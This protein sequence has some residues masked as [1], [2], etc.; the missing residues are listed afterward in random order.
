MTDPQVQNRPTPPEGARPTSETGA[1]NLDLLGS[2]L[3]AERERLEISLREL[4]RRIEVSPSLISQIERG[5]A[6]PSVSTL[7]LLATEL[8]LT[9]DE[10]FASSERAAAPAAGTGGPA[11]KVADAPGGPVQRRDGRKRIRLA[12]GVQWERLTAQPDEEVEF[13]HV[14]YPPGAESCPPDSMFRHGGKE[15]AYVLSGRLGLQIGFE[16]YELEA[17]DSVSFNAQMPHR[18]WAIGDE[19]A[20]AIWVVTNRTND[21]RRAPPV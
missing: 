1:L 7:W 10:L 13:L 4:A 17:G 14:V 5:L 8:G 15:Y 6:M 16:S 19:P 3:R 21:D 11:E 18:L 20:A 9:I 12:G 2:R